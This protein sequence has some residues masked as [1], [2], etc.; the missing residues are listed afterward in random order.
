MGGYPG[1]CYRLGCPGVMYGSMAPG[2]TWQMTFLHARL[3]PPVGFVPVSPSSSL[4]SMGS[5]I[6]STSVPRQHHG[7][8]GGGNGGGGG[9]GAHG[10]GHRRRRG[11]GRS[12]HPG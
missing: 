2:E 6:A 8:D 4:F 12:R 11:G 3:G 10:N 5:G 7:G 1:S 9:G